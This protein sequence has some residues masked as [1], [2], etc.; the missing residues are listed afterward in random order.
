V[1]LDDELSAFVATHRA[2]RRF[3]KVHDVH[4]LITGFACGPLGE[5]Q[6]AAW[7]L[8]TG[9]ALVSLRVGAANL[10][11]LPAGLM[12]DARSVWR[13]FRWGCR[14]RNLYPR[15]VRTRLDAGAWRNVEALRQEFL[16]VKRSEGLLPLRAAEF[17]AYATCA[18]SL[19]A[20]LALPAALLRA[21]RPRPSANRH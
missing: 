20:A 21:F 6:L 7:E 11:S 14:S 17:G 19:H 4:H 12:L 2:R 13:A 3:A 10:A 1:S 5:A 9:S 15:P 8:G 18:L 16:L